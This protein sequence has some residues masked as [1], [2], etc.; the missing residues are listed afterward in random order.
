M[1]QA[2]P[3]TVITGTRKGIGRFLSENYL[4]ENH[5]VIGCSR[6]ESDLNHQNYHHFQCD[7]ADEAQ[8]KNMV[9]TISKKFGYITNLINNAGI[10]SMNHTMLTPYKTVHDI[11]TTNFFG[12][13]LFCREVS[14]IMQKHKYGRIVNFSTVAYP[15][16]LEGE[17]IY[18]SSKA[19]VESYTRILA[20][21][22]G[23][24]GITVNAIGPTPIET[25]LIKS[26]SS[27]KINDLL[28]QQAI[29]RLGD[30]SDIKNV[31]DFFI[32]SESA[33]IT[34]QSIYLGGVN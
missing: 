5:I 26:V 19:A 9:T 6:Q 15:L 34:G 23:S 27:H 2:P 32:K 10:A 16:N 24:I 28:K 29:Q 1:N 18:A 22:L 11:F 7:V 3:I 25:D 12:T 20:K 21:E 30:F 4:D 33:F 8:V 17:A 14:K 31:V 13:F